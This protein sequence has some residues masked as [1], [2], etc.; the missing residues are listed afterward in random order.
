[1][2]NLTQQEINGILREIDIRST[3]EEEKI[4]FSNS[5]DDPNSP[6]NFRY[7]YEYRSPIIKQSALI[8]L[9]YPYLPSKIYHK[10][11]KSC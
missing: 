6:Q 5:K 10:K 4:F 8:I 2:K 3:T 7:R 9:K 11:Q 1:L